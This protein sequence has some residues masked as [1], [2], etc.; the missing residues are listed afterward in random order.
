[1][2]TE[3]LIVAAEQK[4]AEKRAEGDAMTAE[5][6]AL[7]A[8]WPQP[9]PGFFRFLDHVAAHTP[10]NRAKRQREERAVQELIERRTILIQQIEAI[11]ADLAVADEEL[12]A[13]GIQ[14]SLV[15]R[16]YLLVS[17]L[18]LIGIFIPLLYLD[19]NPWPRWNT[20]GVIINL[21]LIVAFI[22]SVALSLPFLTAEER[23]R[24]PRGIRLITRLFTG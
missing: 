23:Q 8:S 21:L 7:I 13:R 16:G 18:A 17:V 24:R 20:L 14:F 11:R 3:Q 15:F 5:Q 1:M 12:E 2:R 9:R 19:P 22:T 6:D 10:S 4:L